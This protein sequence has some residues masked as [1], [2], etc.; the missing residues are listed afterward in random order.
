MLCYL[1]IFNPLAQSML[2]PMLS[3]AFFPCLTVFLV[4]FSIPMTLDFFYIF[5]FTT[6]VSAPFRSTLSS[7]LW[8]SFRL[9]T[10]SGMLCYVNVEKLNFCQTSNS[11]QKTGPFQA[12]SELIDFKYNELYIF[13]LSV[14]G[15]AC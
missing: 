10:G 14:E 5:F 8:I 2:C 6:K 7:S 4:F 15:R 3:F 9:G 12:N 13:L 1:S 11:F